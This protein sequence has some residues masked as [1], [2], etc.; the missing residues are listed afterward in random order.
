MS[1]QKTTVS[2]WILRQPVVWGG[3]S[4]LGF[5]A[6]MG[7][8]TMNNPWVVRYFESHPV[9]QITTFLFFVG[10]AALVLKTLD[11]TRQLASS[12]R[13]IL[14]AIPDGGQRVDH[15]PRL[16]EQLAREPAGLQ[17]SYLV[18][19][20][21]DAIEYVRRRGQA[22]ALDQHL[23]YL[24][25]YDYGRMTASYS[26]VR[27]VIWAIPILGFLGTVIGITMAIAKISPQE[28]EQSL[29][30]V[31]AG[32]SVAFDTTALAL[33]LSI[34]LMFAKF[35]VEKLETRLHELVDARA[36]KELVGRFQQTG[37]DTDPYAASIRRVA[38]ALEGS[39]EH[40][41]TRQTELWKSTIDEAHQ[42]WS[43]LTT[44]ANDLV[45]AAITDGLTT[46][47]SR[48]AESI[49]RGLERFAE[50]IERGVARHEQAVENQ[51]ALQ[52]AAFERGLTHFEATLES[53]IC[54]S[55]AAVS[56]QLEAVRQTMEAVVNSCREAVTESTEVH[57]EA[58]TAN[59]ERHAV[60]LVDL[61]KSL[62]D[63]SAGHLDSLTRANREHFDDVQTLLSQTAERAVT[64]QTELIRQG[65]ILL[66]VVDAT[67][68]VRQLEATL[69]ENLAAVAGSHHFEAGRDEPRD[70]S[71][72][73][74]FAVGRSCR[75]S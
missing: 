48:H 68:Q 44:S 63:E 7:R 33:A 70:R 19:R 58:L 30:S 27:L 54:M 35:L 13:P 43:R 57:R 52:T 6:V 55:T 49:D 53:N 12:Q 14:E 75:D 60:T 10:I 74:H 69:N 50:T 31:V 46:G 41:T 71:A 67:G 65:D 47:L 34:V 73:V 62:A 37:T 25:E 11:I 59:V 8:S 72:A 5:Y 26:V 15:A 16:L 66:K 28:M 24:S 42:Q 22:E 36:S 39:V 40:L 51:S 4:C 18:R 38:E 2:Q 9:E 1:R 21:R 29:G 17:E 45:E 32:L 23:Q 56:E 61:A 64:Q 3:L 20:L